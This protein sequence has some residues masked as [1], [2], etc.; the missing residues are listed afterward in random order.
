[1]AIVVIGDFEWDVE[2]EAANRRKH[3]VTFVEAMSAFLDG[4]RAGRA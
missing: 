3:G 2:K 1:M 4:A